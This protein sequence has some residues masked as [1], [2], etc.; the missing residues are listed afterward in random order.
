MS[1]IFNVFKN[2]EYIHYSGNIDM[3]YLLVAAIFVTCLMPDNV[4]AMQMDAAV[5]FDDESIK[6]TFEFSRSVYIEYTDGGEISELL[7]DRREIIALQINKDRAGM[8]DLVMQLNDSLRLASSEAIVTDAAIKYNVTLQ[9]SENHALIEY[10]IQLTPTI[11]NHVITKIDDASIVDA[12]WYMISIDKPMIIETV[13]GSLDINNPKSALDVIVPNVSEKLKDVTI[14][15]LPLMDKSEMLNVSPDKWIRLIDNTGVFVGEILPP[16]GSNPIRTNYIIQDCNMIT[17]EICHRE[18]LSQEV[19]L[20]KI[21]T[22][23][24]IE[25]DDHAVI[26]FEGFT[27]FSDMNGVEIFQTTLEYQL[28]PPRDEDYFPYGTVI[29]MIVIVMTS[30]IITS[31]ILIRKREISQNQNKMPL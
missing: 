4:F 8:D 1:I 15:E 20:D 22:I 19:E 9:G 14:L 25:P 12:N 18:N 28:P 11:S 13:Y 5:W 10:K 21:Y 17:L 24:I 26:M 2:N 31:I 29:V 6:P 23:K 7:Q 16:F 3:R 30:V 27:T